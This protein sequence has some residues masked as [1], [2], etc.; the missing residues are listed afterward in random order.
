MFEKGYEFEIPA[1]QRWH[2]SYR[3]GPLDL[4]KLNATSLGTLQASLKNLAKDP[5]KLK[6][7]RFRNMTIAPL[8]LKDEIFS[9][10]NT[11]LTQGSSPKRS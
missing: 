2:D 5:A 11:F 9:G 7:P 6:S 10:E 1:D 3:N 4:E 8:G